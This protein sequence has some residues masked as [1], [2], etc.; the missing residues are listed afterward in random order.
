MVKN[1][2]SQEPVKPKTLKTKL[3]SSKWGKKLNPSSPKPDITVKNEE[4]DELGLLAEEEV[5]VPKKV[6]FRRLLIE[7]KVKPPNNADE[8]LLRSA[9]VLERMVI[10]DEN[11]DVAFGRYCKMGG[12]TVRIENVFYIFN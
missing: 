11:I 5:E 3:G 7:D 1:S 9:K 12:L 6:N 8:R 10:Q 4:L 2:F